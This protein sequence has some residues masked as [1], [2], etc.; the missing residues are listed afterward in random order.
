MCCPPNNNGKRKSLQD[1]VHFY[2]VGL[3]LI[4]IFQIICDAATT[5]IWSYPFGLGCVVGIFGIT[6]GS[7][8]ISYSKIK[9]IENFKSA[10]KT[11]IILAYVTIGWSFCIFFYLVQGIGTFMYYYY[12]PI[13]MVGELLCFMIQWGFLFYIINIYGAPCQCCSKDSCCYTEAI[14]D[15]LPETRPFQAQQIPVNAQPQIMNIA[16]PPQSIVYQLPGGQQAYVLQPIAQA[17]LAHAAPVANAA[18]K[19]DE[20]LK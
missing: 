1:V 16:S 17:P 13:M 19:N 20:V 10:F 4:S 12:Y 2:S 9:D 3:L 15:V 8:G 7:L 5:G 18:F 11:V 14:L 6:T